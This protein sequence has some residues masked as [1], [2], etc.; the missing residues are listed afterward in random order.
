MA[1]VEALVVQMS[2]DLRQMQKGFERAIGATNTAA[3]RM[4]SRHKQMAQSIRS[5]S[6]QIGEDFRNVIAGF[7]VAQITRD[8]V[9]LADAWT[10]TGNK[11]RA[12][13]VEV[14]NVSAKQRQ[15]ADLAVTTRTGFAETVDL[16]TRMTRAA[17]SLGA[18]QTEVLR[19]TETVSK[20][21]Q[22]GGASAS[23]A[24]SAILQLS[25]GLASGVLAGDEL[26]AIRE[27]S[28]VVS[29]AIADEF[30]TT[31]GGLKQLGA[32]GKLTADRVFRAI[33]RASEEVDRQFS[34]TNITV[35]GAMTNLRTRLTE[36]VGSNNEAT[37]V[38]V[39][40]AEAINY[41][42]ENF[43][44]IADAALIF[45]AVAAAGIPTFIVIN[46]VAGALSAA[47]IAAGT[48]NVAL[49][50]TALAFRALSGPI[51]IGIFAAVAAMVVLRNYTS[52]ATQATIEFGKIQG[53][54]ERVL[55]NA[56]VAIDGVAAAYGHLTEEQRQ[57]AQESVRALNRRAIA[58]KQAADEAAEYVEF[59]KQVQALPL[60]SKERA[61][62]IQDKGGIYSGAYGS[63]AMSLAEAQRNAARLKEESMIATNRA[64]M[65]GDNLYTAVNEAPK[66]I[67]APVSQTELNR[68]ADAAREARERAAAL[69]DERAQLK[70]TQLEAQG[71]YQMADAL[72]DEM[73]IRQQIARLEELG[74]D[75]G[76]AAQLARETQNAVRAQREEELALTIQARDLENQ[77][78]L[79][80]LAGNQ[81]EAERLELMLQQ[82]QRMRELRD[83][84]LGKDAAQN[85]AQQESADME[86][87]QLRGR[88]RQIFVEAGLAAVDGDFGDSLRGVVTDAFRKGMTD[89]L[90]NLADALFSIVNGAFSQGGGNGLGSLISGGIS[91][92]FGG[93]KA[94]PRASGGP[95]VPGSTYLVG[96]RRAEL[97]T[98]TQAGWITP[99][100]VNEPAKK[101]A[102]PTPIQ[103]VDSRVINFQGTGEE[104]KQLESMLR[105]DKA[106]RQSEIIAT[107]N[108]AMSRRLIA[109]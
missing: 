98:P 76:E 35:G 84:G 8:T 13:G 78:T 4:E 90:N 100:A 57:A 6:R 67:T 14:E 97:F 61:R 108:G 34:L 77:R 15:L 55:N 58:T 12:A 39:K 38:T 37:G 43:D 103:F 63:S 72:R 64:R 60:G 92:I 26:R 52:E 21:L 46:R 53:E 40:L 50:R 20:A 75:P 5:S 88:F 3:R 49:A 74:L 2:V 71:R 25:Q 54:N 42:A 102:T 9:E 51:G 68:A 18:T 106:Q 24:N 81:R 85:Q 16:Y 47:A 109:S 19:L 82:V 7:A 10:Q 27:N 91:A 65:V 66:R 45:A 95:V 22:V 56:R 89:A 36:Y 107:V 86:D 69:E 83:L 23:E 29:Q 28:T 41:V 62:V 96:E 80:A 44:R 17:S 30:N 104:L 33:L 70:I 93:G 99:K 105:A 11:L 59:L 31:I 79:A 87:A 73:E 48:A 32:E 1:D 94:K 101:G